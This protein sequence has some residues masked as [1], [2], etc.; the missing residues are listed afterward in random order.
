LDTGG[1]RAGDRLTSEGIEEVEAR[2]NEADEAASLLHHR[3]AHLVHTP[4]EQEES[5]FQKYKNS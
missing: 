1:E 4:V 3:H 2:L 5:C